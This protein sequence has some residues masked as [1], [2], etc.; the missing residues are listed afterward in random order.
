MKIILSC[1]L[2]ALVST[3]STSSFA[4]AAPSGLHNKTVSLSWG[5]TTTWRRLSDNKTGSSNFVI[6]REIYISS[7]GR[8][9]VRNRGVSG[10]VGGASDSGPEKT[11]SRV[12]FNGNTMTAFSDR[13]GLLWHITVN[14]EP[15][16][17]SCSATVSIAREGQKAKTTGVDGAEYENLSASAASPSCSVKEGN[18]FA[19]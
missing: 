13:G 10:A 5:Q 7:A 6:A 12:V 1:A 8:S 11:A 14:F 15:S 4:G 17:S 2:A 9:F 16:F 19:G 3:L 18:T